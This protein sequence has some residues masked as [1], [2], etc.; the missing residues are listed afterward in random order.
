M[1]RAEM[2]REQKEQKRKTKTYVLTHEQIQKIRQQE[3][4]KARKQ[5]LDKSEELASEI[6]KMMLVIPTNILVNDYWKKTAETRIPKF[7]EDCIHLYESW[8]SG[9]VNVEEMC[10]LTERYGKIKLIEEDGPVGNT[11]R[12]L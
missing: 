5:I 1:N 11:L 2:R 12:K 6:F 4:A 3:Y 7:V 10:K 9:S 8:T